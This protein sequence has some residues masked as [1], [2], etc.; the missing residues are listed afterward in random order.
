MSAQNRNESRNFLGSRPSFRK[1]LA[2]AALGLTAMLGLDAAGALR[3]MSQNSQQRSPFEQGGKLTVE[4]LG[5]VLTSYGK[6]TSNVNG[7]VS[8]SI[9]M[10]KGK[11]TV[12]VILSI[13][14]NGNVIWLM[15]NMAPMPEPARASAPALI[16]LLKKN[17][18][19]GPMFF[20]ISNGRLSLT[21]PVANHD[22]TPEL[23]KSYIERFCSTVLDT[24]PL[25]N[26]DA[27]TAK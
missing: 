10:T 18:E 26:Q 12:N 20:E 7:D 3:A 21:E 16:N 24:M 1:L 9:N 11:Y 15:N 17:L 22:M 27:L 25:W 13:S 19:L 23:V 2:I 8:Y 6:N 4:Q 5:D 14:P